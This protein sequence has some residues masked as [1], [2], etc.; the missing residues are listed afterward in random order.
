MTIENEGESDLREGIGRWR[1]KYRVADSDPALAC[2][3]LFDLYVA[4]LRQRAP[5]SPPLRYEEFRSTM[6]LLDARSKGFIKHSVELIHEL[7]QAKQTSRQLRR[8]SLYALGLTA[9]AAF[10]AGVLTGIQMR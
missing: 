2:V 5:D 6:E 9:L 4:S 7:R 10:V 1:Q 3:E 8:L